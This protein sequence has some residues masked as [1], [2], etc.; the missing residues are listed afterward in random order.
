MRQSGAYMTVEAAMVV[1]V[2]IV[3]IVTIVY[4]SLYQYDRCMMEQDLALLT[5]FAVGIE[6]DEA[7]E[8]QLRTRVG[9]VDVTQY[10][11]CELEEFEV[12]FAGST[13]KAKLKGEFAYPVSGWNWM[14][15]NSGW[16]IGAYME[17]KRYSPEGVLRGMKKVKEVFG[18]EN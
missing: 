14:L 18:D 12:E 6:H 16:D 10:L 5:V 15:E 4:L 7:S 9:Q 2:A 17:L 8:D 1:P 13:A 11:N 3:A